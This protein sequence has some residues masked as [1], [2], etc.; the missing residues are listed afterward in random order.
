MSICESGRATSRCVYAHNIQKAT[1]VASVNLNGGVILDSGYLDE[2]SD[3][4]PNPDTLIRLGSKIDGTKD[5]IVLSVYQGG[6][7]NANYFGSINVLEI[8]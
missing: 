7:P 2:A 5:V 3:S 4:F 8:S 1:N 6:T